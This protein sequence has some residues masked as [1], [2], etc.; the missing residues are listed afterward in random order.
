MLFYYYAND[1]RKTQ[2]N[3]TLM[4]CQWY[5]LPLVVNDPSKLLRVRSN[6]FNDGKATDDPK[7]LALQL[8]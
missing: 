6:V 1:E 7:I 5:N 8:F 4:S 3:T 2:N